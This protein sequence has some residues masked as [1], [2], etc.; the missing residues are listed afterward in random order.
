M[1]FE[2]AIAVLVASLAMAGVAHAQQNM[3]P[4]NDPAVQR[5]IDQRLIKERQDRIDACVARQEANM[6]AMQRLDNHERL[7][8]NCTNAEPAAVTSVRG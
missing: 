7:T 5:G 8:A 6:T 2:K 4:T 3:N 1:R